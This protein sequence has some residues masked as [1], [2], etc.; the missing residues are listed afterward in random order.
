M[1]AGQDV[2]TQ[3]LER[4][5]FEDV[6]RL[7]AE[8]D[9][10]GAEQA[11]KIYDVLKAQIEAKHELARFDAETLTIRKQITDNDEKQYKLYESFSAA[12]DARMKKEK[13]Y[14]KF[15]K[16]TDEIVMDDKTYRWYQRRAS[17]YQKEIDSLKLAEEQA[18]STY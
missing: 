16:D 3:M 13:E 8:G 17:R 7:Q 9:Y 14:A 1:T 12:Q 18:W 11:N 6:M 15:E 4:Q 10:D 5:R 2:E